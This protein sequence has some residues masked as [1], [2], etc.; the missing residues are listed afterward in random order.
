MMRTVL[1]I[2]LNLMIFFVKSYNTKAELKEGRRLSIVTMICISLLKSY[3]KHGCDLKF[4]TG[5]LNK[6]WNGFLLEL[7]YRNTH[8]HL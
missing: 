4:T 6:L 3:G 8:R 2:F 1:S 5:L 7:G